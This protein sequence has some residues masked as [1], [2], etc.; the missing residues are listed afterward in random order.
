MLY[1]LIH[2]PLYIFAKLYFRYTG[3]V[4][5]GRILSDKPNIFLVTQPH[6]FLDVVVLMMFVK[7]PLFF[8]IRSDRFQHPAVQF[9]LT[10]WHIMLIPRASV[11]QYGL[12]QPQGVLERCRDLLIQNKSIVIFGGGLSASGQKNPTLKKGAAK[13]AFAAE[14]IFDFKLDIQITPVRVVHSHGSRWMHDLCIHFGVP[15]LIKSWERSYKSN[16]ARAIRQLTFTLEEAFQPLKP[17]VLHVEDLLLAEKLM[18]LESLCGNKS[19]KQQCLERKQTEQEIVR[20]LNQLRKRMP[21]DLQ[22]LRSKVKQY[23]QAIHR[24]QLS[25]TCFSPHYHFSVLHYL[26]LPL[27]PL[28]LLGYLLNFI[29]VALAKRMVPQP[30]NASVLTVSFQLSCTFIFVALYMVSLF[31][32]GY[33]WSLSWGVG[34]C[35]GVPLLG[36]FTWKSSSMTQKIMDHI[37]LVQFIKKYPEEWKTMKQ[38]QQEIQFYFFTKKEVPVKV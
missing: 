15:V 12:A 26:L 13:I 5:L 6:S 29:P 25:E 36:L 31:F 22:L 14:E 23:V 1:R 9:F 16:P 3:A 33:A 17:T 7:K 10:L 21:Y 35:L 27:L 38:L 8:L 4:G 30:V 32:L 34:L 2:V 18:L 37:R 20:K 19:R 11:S 24:F 28:Y